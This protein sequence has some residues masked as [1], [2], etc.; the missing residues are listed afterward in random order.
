MRRVY[1]LNLRHLGALLQVA[2]AGNISAA[3]EAVSLS[4]PALVQA[5]A[6]LEQVLETALFVRHPHGVT[7]TEAGGHFLVRTRRALGYL[8]RGVQQIRRASRQPMLAHV[9]RRVSMSQLRALVSVVESSSY[10]GAA[11]QLGLS[12][13]SLHRAMRELQQVVQVTLLERAGRSIRPTAPAGRLVHFVHLMLAE[14]RAGIDEVSTRDQGLGGQLRVGVMPVARAHFLPR[15]LAGFCRRRPAAF[16]DIIEGPYAELL[17]RLRQG[18][19]DVLIASWRENIAARDVVQEVLFDDELVIVG[20]AGHPLQGRDTLSTAELVAHPWVVPA[21]G[22]PMRLSWERM[23][24]VRGHA[25]PPLRVQCGSVMIMRGL[26]LE[27]D[28]LALM[29]RD[30]FRLESQAGR[31]VELGSPGAGFGRRIAMTRRA[32]WRPT[33]LQSAFVEAFRAVRSERGTP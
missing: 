23:F 22:V 20:R 9:E 17:A 3:A 30:Q 13:P 4:Q 25:P 28:W 26:M 8:E 10:A 21:P 2:A 5:I 24:Q 27:D 19:M 29:S 33:P 16:V 1:S 6:K 11:A 12:Q 15:V 7:A 14:L 32:D 18:D 31:L